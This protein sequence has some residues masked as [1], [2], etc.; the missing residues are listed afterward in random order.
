M[1]DLTGARTVY[2]MLREAGAK[3]VHSRQIIESKCPGATNPSERL[4]EV[5]NHIP[6]RKRSERY[7]RS[8]G[9]RAWLPEHAPAD[10]VPVTPAS[11]ASSDNDS[12][13]EG[14]GSLPPALASESIAAADE[15]RSMTGP[16]AIVRDWDGVWRELPCDESGWPVQEAA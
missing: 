9:V 8:P 16:V 13:R 11:T 4:R 10:A 14:K 2:V 3:G 7:G 6:I 15:Q 1:S 12:E 5:A